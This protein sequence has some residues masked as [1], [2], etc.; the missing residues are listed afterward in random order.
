MLQRITLIFSFLSILS[1]ADEPRAVMLWKIE[2]KLLSETSYLF[3]TYHSRDKEI[4]AIPPKVMKLLSTTQKLY[5]ETELTHENYAWVQNFMRDSNLR[6]LEHRL[7]APVYK[8]LQTFIEDFS[9]PLSIDQLSLFKTWA[10]SLLLMNYAESKTAAHVLFM[11]E[12]LVAYAKEKEI[13]ALGLETA[14]EQLFYFDTLSRKEQEYLLTDSMNQLENDHYTDALKQWYIKGDIEGFN[15]LQ[16]R[17]KD[18]NPNIEALDTKLFS[19]LLTER[20]IRFFQRMDAVLK[21][22]PHKNYFFAVGAAHLA[23][24]NGLVSLLRKAGYTVSKVE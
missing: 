14:K 22:D 1:L 7:S 23:E 17:F 18:K 16:Q 6:N 21:N 13:P 8:R 4:N 24:K 3:G 10:I 12:R 20:N 5:T 19:L 9:L 11:D 2:H 15:Q